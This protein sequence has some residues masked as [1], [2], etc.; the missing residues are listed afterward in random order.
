M[1]TLVGSVPARTSQVGLS[2]S[3]IEGGAPA[4]REPGSHKGLCLLPGSQIPGLEKEKQQQLP[5]VFPGN[6]L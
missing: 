1:E 4:L 6:L 3:P 5:L 2:V